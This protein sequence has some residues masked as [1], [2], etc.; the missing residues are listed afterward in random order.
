MLDDLKKRKEMQRI[1]ADIF[2]FRWRDGFKVAI[3]SLKGKDW[4]RK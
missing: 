1:V 3:I 4:Q 2:M